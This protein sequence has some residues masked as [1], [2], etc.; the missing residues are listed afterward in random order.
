LVRIEAGSWGW[1]MLNSWKG[2]GH[3]GLAVIRESEM[4]P[5]GAVAIRTT[6]MSV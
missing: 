4:M 5:M 2:W 1:L 3:H 6:T